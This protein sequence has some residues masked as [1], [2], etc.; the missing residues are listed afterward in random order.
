MGAAR[1]PRAPRTAENNDRRPGGEQRR[2]TVAE[3]KAESEERQP[4]GHCFVMV[5]WL[6]VVLRWHCVCSFVYVLR[7]GEAGRWE[8]RE[9]N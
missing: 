1:A 7:K 4:R 6:G 8:G 3:R 9:K 5:G 2:T